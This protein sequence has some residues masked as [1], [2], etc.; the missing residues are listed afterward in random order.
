MS[1][2]DLLH[3]GYGRWEDFYFDLMVKSHLAIE[4]TQD[5]FLELDRL[6]RRGCLGYLIDRAKENEA[7]AFTALEAISVV[8]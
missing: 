6:E 8:I 1:K 2:K 5:M 7:D 3:R 4:S